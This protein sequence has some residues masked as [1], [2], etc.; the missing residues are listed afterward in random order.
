MAR[1]GCIQLIYVIIAP[2]D[3]ANEGDRIFRSHQTW[4]EATHHRSGPKALLSYDVSK[5]SELSN[6]ADPD[7]LPTGNTIFILSEVYRTEAGVAD[8]YE[9]A[10]ASWVDFDAMVKWLDKCETTLVPSAHIFN[11]LW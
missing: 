8:H 1:Q 6:P 2:P 10:Q 3:Q 5:T 4:M 7:S 9:Q 11:S